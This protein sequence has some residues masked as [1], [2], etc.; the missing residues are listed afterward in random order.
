MGGLWRDYT[1]TLNLVTT[2][3]WKEAGRKIGPLSFSYLPALTGQSSLQWGLYSFFFP[4]CVD[5]PLWAAAGAAISHDTGGVGMIP[6][7]SPS[8]P[9]GAEDCG[10]V[11]TSALGLSGAQWVLQCAGWAAR[12]LGYDM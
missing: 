11:S 4:G 8:L 5:W 9:P 2:V 7:H 10:P 3:C 1:E 12:G 6:A